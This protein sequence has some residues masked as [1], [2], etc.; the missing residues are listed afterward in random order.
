MG[1]TFTVDSRFCGPKASG[2]GGYVC[3]RLAA[4]IDGPAQASLKAPPPLDTLLR[5]VREAEGVSAFHGEMLVGT[6][7]PAA[8]DI[9]PPAV[10]TEAAIEAARAA[11]LDHQDLHLLP[12]CFVCGP[13][14]APGDGL[15][16]FAGPAGEIVN[17][18]HWTP[19]ADLADADGLVRPE[20]LWAALDC[21]SYFALRAKVQMA[22]LAS[23]AA[24]VF[25]RP[26]AGE[27]LT[28][29]A[30]A[31][32]SQGRKHNAY[33]ALLDAEGETLALAEALWIAIEDPAFVQRL[34]TGQA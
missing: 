5:V 19:A 24:D 4:Y 26:R 32:T 31:G 22:L 30:W 2:N 10:P 15:R 12:H 11:Y 23:L 33:S 34:Q 8:V 25:R 21:P 17:A 13:K 28:V 16:I 20:F 6:A 7:K 9:E 1:D 18:D 3:G 14:R 29:L 27:R